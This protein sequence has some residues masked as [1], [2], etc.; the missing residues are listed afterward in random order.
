LVDIKFSKEAG[1]I[2]PPE[3]SVTPGGDAVDLYSA[4]IRPVPQGIGMNMEQ[5]GYFPYGHHVAHLVIS[6]HVFHSLLFN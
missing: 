2:V 3:S 4:G 1:N 5:A 6:Y